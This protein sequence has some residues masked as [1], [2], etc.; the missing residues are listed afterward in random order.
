LHADLARVDHAML[1][2]N[3]APTPE[4]PRIFCEVE[5]GVVMALEPDRPSWFDHALGPDLSVGDPLRGRT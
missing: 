3:S 2:D 4:G 1:Y 5:V